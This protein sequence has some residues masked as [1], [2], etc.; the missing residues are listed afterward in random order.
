MLPVCR[1]CSEAQIPMPQP[2]SHPLSHGDEEEGRQHGSGGVWHQH[3]NEDDSHRRLEEHALATDCATSGYPR[4]IHPPATWVFL[5]DAYARS[6]GRPPRR[7][8]GD[9]TPHHGF[10]VPF[11]VR[12]DGPRGRSA[13][14]ASHVKRGTEVCGGKHVV[15]FE[16]ARGMVQFLTLLPAPLQCDVLLWAFESGKRGHVYVALDEGSFVNHGERTEL[17]T[18][19]GSTGCAALRDLAPGDELLEDYGE[20][21]VNNPR[22]WFHRLREQ[23]WG[24]GKGRERSLESYVSQGVPKIGEPAP[25]G[26]K[27][28]DLETRGRLHDDD[29][30]EGNQP[31]SRLDYPLS[32]GR[33]DNF[34][35]HTVCGI[36]FSVILWRRWFRQRKEKQGV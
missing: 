35:L 34:G 19:G 32:Q 25:H 21:V 9:S 18:L 36:V 16:D 26:D 24:K 13:Y 30:D 8:R 20:F 10:K 33:G 17:V 28:S 6:R 4:T 11:Q 3:G 12:D 29:D 15:H 1:I 22:G 2:R 31:T 14:A 7:R 23:A 5:Q 27:R